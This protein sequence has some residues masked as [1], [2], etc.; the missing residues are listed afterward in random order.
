MWIRW[1]L[2][3][4]VSRSVFGH[5]FLVILRWVVWAC[6][7]WLIFTVSSWCSHRFG[8]TTPIRWGMFLLIRCLCW[9]KCGDLR[10]WPILCWNRVVY[11][12]T[13]LLKILYCILHLFLLLRLSSFSRQGRISVGWWQVLFYTFCEWLRLLLQTAL[14]FTFLSGV[15]S[16]GW[17][18]RRGCWCWDSQLVWC[19]C[20]T[21]GVFWRRT[22]RNWSVCVD[23]FMVCRI[24]WVDFSPESRR[25][26]LLRD[27]PLSTKVLFLLW[28]YSSE[29]LT[30]S[31][32]SRRLA[33]FLLF[34]ETN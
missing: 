2:T 15:A 32:R 8:G 4:W 27:L 16:E 19:C 5:R 28:V 3:V 18:F 26:I 13:L 14:V 6:W 30:Y 31:Y 21:W 25:S 34:L 23:K 22:C 11:S 17:C 9:L 24:F 1:R 33:R 12:I 29:L 7:R 20:S 10:G